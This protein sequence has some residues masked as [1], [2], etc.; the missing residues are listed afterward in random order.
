LKYI[1]HETEMGGS[2]IYVGH[3]KGTTLIFMYASEYPEETESLLKG[4]IALSPIA[5]MDPRLPSKLYFT[6]TPTIGVNSSS[7]NSTQNV[8]CMFQKALKAIGVQALFLNWKD[9]QEFF[10]VLCSAMPHV[11]EFII[12]QTSGELLQFMPVNYIIDIL[13]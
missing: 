4:I 3:S 1:A 11:C 10:L 8:A 9:R 5:Y 2:I 13:N 12:Y 6:V 7:S